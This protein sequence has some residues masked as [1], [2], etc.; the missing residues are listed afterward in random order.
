VRCQTK[1]IKYPIRSILNENKK[2]IFYSNIKF[3]ALLVIYKEVIQ[4][5]NIGG[6]YS[7]VVIGTN[8]LT[9]GAVYIAVSDKILY[10]FIS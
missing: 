9:I 2:E 6:Y 1:S 4:S 3:E 8:F 5:K 10:L 7:K